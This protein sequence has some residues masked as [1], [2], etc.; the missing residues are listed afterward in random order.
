MVLGELVLCELARRLSRTEVAHTSDMKASLK[1][2][3]AYAGFRESKARQ[4]IF[5]AAARYDVS[6]RGRR[7]LDLGCFDGAISQVY[8][9]EGATHVYGVD[10]DAAAIKRARTNFTDPRL[11]FETG[12]VSTIPLPD[13]CVDVV[14]SYDVFEHVSRI[15]TILRELERVL[16]PGGT[17]LIGTWGWWHPFAPHLFSA[18]PVPWAHVVFSERTVLKACRRV[19]LS[20]WYQPTMHD[21]DDEGRRRPDKY[22]HT[23]ISTD[24]LNKYL[25]RD[26]ERDF[27]ASGLRHETHL[28]PFGSRYARWTRP[29]LAVPML[30]EFL[31]GYVWF[32]LTKP[33]DAA[34]TPQQVA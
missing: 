20:N 32:V 28:V 11:T 30:R 2:A 5:E 13:R 17:V 10:I 23:S 7:V 26:F 24:Y 9:D 19:Y 34:A 21:F 14:V 8:L 27:R 22:T 29:L 16:T 31:A 18:M 6:V 25:I 12:T 3:D 1:D 4:H 15:S 33:G